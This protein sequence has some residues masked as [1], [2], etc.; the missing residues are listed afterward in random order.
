[1]TRAGVHLEAKRLDARQRVG[2]ESLHGRDSNRHR[3]R[4]D[5]LGSRVAELPADDVR[6]AVAVLKS[7]SLSESRI[8]S[9]GFIADCTPDSTR[10]PPG[11][12]PT[13]R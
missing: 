6:E 2:S 1:M 8:S 12:R 9:A 3:R 7:A 5:G 4:I 10:P 11:T 13:V